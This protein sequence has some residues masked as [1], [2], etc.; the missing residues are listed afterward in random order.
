MLPC[1]KVYELGYATATTSKRC[2]VVLKQPV[3]HLGTI[4]T[5]G[6]WLGLRVLGGIHF[7]S[8]PAVWARWGAWTRPNA[9]LHRS[10]DPG[11]YANLGIYRST[12]LKQP[13][14]ICSAIPST[15]PPASSIQLLILVLLP[16]RH[17]S[18]AGPLPWCLTSKPSFRHSNV[19]I[20]LQAI[21]LSCLPDI[22]SE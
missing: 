20:S 15:R 11:T 21:R 2:M 16:M 6:S 4:A 13:Q 18:M 8:V 9:A 12:H 3:H 1:A 22:I 10:V 7:D 19:S 14:A 17:A 5:S